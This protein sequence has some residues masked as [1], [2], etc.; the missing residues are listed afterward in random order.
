[1]AGRA[2]ITF[3]FTKRARI[4]VKMLRSAQGER[5]EKKERLSIVVIFSSSFQIPLANRRRRD[6][7]MNFT[8]IFRIS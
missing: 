6:P 8:E 5:Y 7:I 3:A 4:R 2:A 1:M